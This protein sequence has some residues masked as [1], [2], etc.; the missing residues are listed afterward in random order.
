MIINGLATR[1]I[2]HQT[3][4]K[5]SYIGISRF[6]RGQRLCI[7]QCPKQARCFATGRQNCNARDEKN[8][9]GASQ[10][11]NGAG[12]SK[13]PTD[14]EDVIRRWSS[15]S[16]QTLLWD[17]TFANTH[18]ALV[19]LKTDL[20]DKLTD[21]RK[22][23]E[24]AKD[25]QEDD[26][27]EIILTGYLGGVRQANKDLYFGVLADPHMR[28]TIQIVAR[29]GESLRTAPKTTQDLHAAAD[30]TDA[31]QQ[32]TASNNTTKEGLTSAVNGNNV[33]GEEQNL[34]DPAADII[35]IEGSSEAIASS[36]IEATASTS[37]EADSRANE[38]KPG[39]G[40]LVSEDTSPD[41]YSGAVEAASHESSAYFQD[42]LSSAIDIAA[43]DG[44]SQSETSGP[45]AS[46]KGSE[47]SE[48]VSNNSD[49]PGISLVLRSSSPHTPITIWGRIRSR[50]V[51]DGYPRLRKRVSDRYFGNVETFQTIEI[52]ISRIGV[53]NE[54]HVHKLREDVKFADEQRHLQ[55]RTSSKLRLALRLR[56]KALAE[57]RKALFMDGFDEI[58]TPLLFR[59]SREGAREFIV[60]SRTFGK[61]YALPQSPQQYKQ[62]LMA[63]GIAKYFQFA[64]CFRD[65]DLRTDRQ[66]EFTQLDI[67]MSFANQRTIIITM[68]KVIRKLWES[69][70][71][72]IS[73]KHYTY[74][75][76]NNRESMASPFDELFYEDAMR[77]FGTDKPDRRI[78]SMIHQPKDF[79]QDLINKITTI[80]DP[81][82]DMMKFQV[83][84]N[85][86]VSRKFITH[87]LESKA[88]SPFRPN[89][90]SA[91]GI[92]II[93]ESKP[94]QGL[95]AFG[96]E[97][98]EKIKESLRLQNGDLVVITARANER[99][100]GSSTMMGDMR[101][102]LFK[103]A[104]QEGHRTA[105]TADDFVWITQFPLFEQATPDDPGQGGEAGIRA[106][107]HPFTAPS[108]QN[109]AALLN[110]IND[111]LALRGN[112]FDLVING[113]EVG[114]GS[115]RIHRADMQELIFRNVLKMSESDMEAFQPLL[116]A[117]SAACPPH[118]GMALGFDRLLAVLLKKET[119]R[120]VIAFPKYGDG[121]D[122]MV[123][124][125]AP[126]TND[127]LETYSLR[128][129]GHGPKE[130]KGVPIFFH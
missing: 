87:F 17:V 63:S 7:P 30:S 104:V 53:H 101:L 100:S 16:K 4:L 44:T 33:E 84:D 6:V 116:N 2:R 118:A 130:Q 46:N 81:V 115:V 102:A 45:N 49:F 51:P 13:A 125:P 110:I 64:K 92:F 26:H 119:I 77:S 128:K 71:H 19:I 93:D 55:L 80:R 29:N 31:L 18:Q 97:A 98:A 108:H 96:F 122:R 78:G 22:L 36:D 91:P 20:F 52:E 99:M 72:P 5:S 37:S 35:N 68:E 60:P 114:G 103:A 82:I 50:K 47:E 70:K 25:F 62:I 107:H 48:T 74:P 105:P 21:F 109:K 3:H 56:S 15:S 123:G 124:S 126:I 28:R 12:L 39:E 1:T 69:M 27:G 86:S 9:Q 94:M 111:P 112:S 66:P 73:V 54:N 24:I 127:Q 41:K 57:I 65:E 14:P 75:A 90:V 88:G 61:A 89:P 23:E 8:L 95:S 83:S 32:H 34:K 11:T 58:E 10:S 121:Q 79:P 67:E 59:S 76:A 42:R 113:V 117:L 120:D 38:T 85:P 106:R 43:E 129:R 40:V